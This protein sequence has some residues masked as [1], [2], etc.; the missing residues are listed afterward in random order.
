MWIAL[1][2]I[3]AMWIVG[4]VIAPDKNGPGVFSHNHTPPA[5][6]TAANQPKPSVVPPPR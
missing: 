6:A 4:A 3:G 2:I 1:G 5:A